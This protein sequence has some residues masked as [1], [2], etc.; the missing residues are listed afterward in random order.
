MKYV[1]PCF[2]W[3]FAMLPL[4]RAVSGLRS[5]VVDMKLYLPFA[6]KLLRPHLYWAFISLNF[7]AFGLFVSAG[8]LMLRE[9]R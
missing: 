2:F 9:L 8:F 4:A 6:S 1:L 5:G 7:L 3:V